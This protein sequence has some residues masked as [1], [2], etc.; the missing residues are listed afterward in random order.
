MTVVL[1]LFSIF[2]FRMFFYYS[3]KGLVLYLSLLLIV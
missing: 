3:Y 2:C 1:N